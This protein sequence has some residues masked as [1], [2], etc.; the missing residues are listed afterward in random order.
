MKN[1]KIINWV[2]C[3][4]TV[5]FLTTACSSNVD[6][7]DSSTN[8]QS[9][10]SALVEALTAF[11]KKTLAETT[12][13][14]V[15]GHTLDVIVEDIYGAYKGGKKGYQFGKN[16]LDKRV[17]IACTLLCGAIYGGYRSYKA[18][19]T[20]GDGK[21][22]FITVGEDGFIDRKPI[23][24]D[25]LKLTIYAS[26]PNDVC[27]LNRN[28][29]ILKDSLAWQEVELDS[30][31]LSSVNLTKEQLNI[32]QLHNIVLAS[33]DGTLKVKNS[34]KSVESNDTIIKSVINSP[35]IEK[36]YNVMGTEQESEYFND[37]DPLPDVIMKLFNEVFQGAANDY[38]TVVRLINEYSEKIDKTDELSESQKASIK[39]GLATA[40]Y[41]FNYWNKKTSK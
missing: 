11:N 27:K 26:A 34:Y 15:S 7:A 21:N 36:L 33:M 8:F 38:A 24:F 31:L 20:Y 28:S 4:I 41:S 22:K 12:T 37:S 2:V 6:D 14:R 17:T 32:G 5:L 30:K 39:N 29:V 10:N 19:P 9:E 23:P 18:A 1:F 16:F 35:E 25:S 3:A 13:T 40:L